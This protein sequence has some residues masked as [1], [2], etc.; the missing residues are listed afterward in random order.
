[1]KFTVQH[2]RKYVKCEYIFE[3][4]C[5][6]S[7]FFLWHARSAPTNEYQTLSAFSSRECG[8]YVNVNDP[9]LPKSETV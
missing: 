2:G 9:T 8:T 6:A 5:V 4:H 1:M 3:I 7:C